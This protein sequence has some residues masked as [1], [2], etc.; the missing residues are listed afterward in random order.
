[1]R[2][3]IWI[4]AAFL[5]VSLTTRIGLAIFSGQPFEAGQWVRIV[6]VGSIYDLA[7]AP[8]LLLPWALYDAI[9]PDLARSG[10]LARWEAIWAMAWAGLYL[11]LFAVISIAEFAFWAEFASR[12][13]FIA[14][15]YLIYTHEVIGNIRESYPV[16]LWFAIIAGGAGIVTWFSWPRMARPA[17][18]GWGPRLGILATL[19]APLRMRSSRSSPATGSILS[20]MPTGT[21]SWTTTSIIPRSRLLRRTAGSAVWSRSRTHPSSRKRASSAR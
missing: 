11:S 12:F 16:A 3:L 18:S 19:S 8:W 5:L 21:I 9:M 17:R 13:D 14:V 2:R 6:L 15:D 10:R 4:G 7:I 20:G 1:M